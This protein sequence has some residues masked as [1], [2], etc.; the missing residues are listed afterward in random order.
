MATIIT[1]FNQKGGVGKTTIA[2]HLAGTL[3]RRGSKVLL[4]DADP[5]GSSVAWVTNAEEG[6]EMPMRVAN[7]SDAGRK[8]HTQVRPYIDSS[9]FIVIDCPPHKSAA[10]TQSALL[11]SDIALMPL[12]PSPAD[13]W[14]SAGAEDL[15]EQ[16][17]A[18]N[19]DLIALAVWNQFDRRRMLSQAAVEA[20]RDLSVTPIKA[21]IGYRES[22]RKAAAIGGLVHNVPDEA[23]VQEIEQMTSN[24]LSF[25]PVAQS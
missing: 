19:E 4:V 6:Q 20:I 12:L 7:L 5:Q 17:R 21:R 24:V 10:T 2:V 11:V 15:L 25:L 14:A 8:L 23:A 13:I 1:V 16:A 9:D 3:A 18:V 22:F